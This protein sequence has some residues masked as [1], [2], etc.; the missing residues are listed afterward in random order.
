MKQLY[1][2][3]ITLLGHCYAYTQAPNDAIGISHAKTTTL[4]FPADILHVDRGAAAILVQDIKAVKNVLMVK[5]AYP[6]IEESNLSIFTADGQLYSLTVCFEAAPAQYVYRVSLKQALSK[7]FVQQTALSASTVSSFAHH[8][9][10]TIPTLKGPIAHKWGFSALLTGLFIKGE[11]LFFQF[12]LKNTSSLD[13]DIGSISLLLKD[14]QRYKRAAIQ[15]N[16]IVPLCV[17]GNT[18]RIAARQTGV[19]I[20]AIPRMTIPKSKR[21]MVEIL[22]KQSS[23]HVRLSIKNRSIFQARPLPGSH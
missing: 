15:D 4:V 22:E 1:M 11:V 2:V 18:Q 12:R 21:L 16:Q 9:L 19:L 3:V 7:T 13:Y 6:N 14:R 23:R 10:A 5:A 8:L 17:V 20:I